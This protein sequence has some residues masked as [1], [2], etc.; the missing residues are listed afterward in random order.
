[1]RYRR[2]AKSSK[3]VFKDVF[4]YEVV[5]CGVGVG[6]VMGDGTEELAWN[7]KVIKRKNEQIPFLNENNRQMFLEYTQK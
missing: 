1:M 7:R 5:L 3:G 6:E 2:I 4:L